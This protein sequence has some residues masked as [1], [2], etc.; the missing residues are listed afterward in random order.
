MK[1][2]AVFINRYKKGRQTFTRKSK[3]G[4]LPTVP[5]TQKGGDVTKVYKDFI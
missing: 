4:L 2:I 5:P 1:K 3:H